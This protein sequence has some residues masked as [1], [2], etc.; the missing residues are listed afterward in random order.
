[1]HAACNILSL[2]VAVQ[3]C[4]HVARCKLNSRHRARVTIAL[5]VWRLH[6]RTTRTSARTTTHACRRPQ[7]E[8]RV[9][10]S[11]TTEHQHPVHLRASDCN[12]RWLV[13]VHTHQHNTHTVLDASLLS[14]GCLCHSLT[15]WHRFSLLP[16]VGWPSSR[17]MSLD[18]PCSSL[19][20]ASST[21]SHV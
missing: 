10:G 13:V 4:R 9:A 5:P 11:T 12:I 21:V 2:I 7:S 17:S 8:L 14:D 1:M 6:D 16:S 18:I 3:S 20:V 15:S 19:H